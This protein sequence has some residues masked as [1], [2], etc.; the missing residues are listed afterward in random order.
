MVR[1][2]TPGLPEEELAAL[3]D[4]LEEELLEELELELED[5]LELDDEDD[6]LELDES[7][8]PPQ[9]IRPAAMIPTIM[10]CNVFIGF[11]SIFFF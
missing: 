11:T 6:E 3:D 4:E 7:V 10:H 9:A 1:V 2:T 5:E 8:P